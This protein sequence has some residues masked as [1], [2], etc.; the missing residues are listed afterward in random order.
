MLKPIECPHKDN[1]IQYSHAKE[2]NKAYT[3]TDTERQTAHQQGKYT[4]YRTHRD[5]GKNQ[6]CLP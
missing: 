2:R 3:S 6:T 1:T 4:S 5:S